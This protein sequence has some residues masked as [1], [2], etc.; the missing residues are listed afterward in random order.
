MTAMPKFLSLYFSSME[1]EEN[2]LSGQQSRNHSS[3]L[4]RFQANITSKTSKASSEIPSH[5]W[6]I[7][8]SQVVSK[9]FI[10][11]CMKYLDS[12]IFLINICSFLSFF[13]WC[14]LLI[15]YITFVFRLLAEWDIQIRMH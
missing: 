7:C 4:A 15:I 14:I 9:M 6:Y 5:K 10:Y 13:I 1:I 11:E 3:I 12:F 2:N 8:I